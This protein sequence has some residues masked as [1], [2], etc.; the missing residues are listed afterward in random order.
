MEV[1]LKEWSSVISALGSGRQI[2]LLRKGGIVESRKGFEV[3]HRDFVLFPTF[4]HQ[5]A[6]FLKPEWS[7]ATA[8]E[9]GTGDQIRIEFAAKVTDVVPAPADRNRWQN[10]DQHHIWN[11][12]LIDMRY[13]YRPDLPLYIL[14][15]R[16]YAVYPQLI[17][18][19]PSYAGCKSWVNLTDEVKLDEIQPVLDD[20]QY[21][22]QRR[23][24]LSDLQLQ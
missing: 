17:L 18:D 4:A 15:A 14:L 20:M 6:S 5:H 9:P 10:M 24:L 16:I 21:D 2:L 11:D 12:A 7:T 23:M 22:E 1:A 8:G 13:A 19:R 3:R